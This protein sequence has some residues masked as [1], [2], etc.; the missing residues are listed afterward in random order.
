MNFDDNC[1][2]RLEKILSDFKEFN[3]ENREDF[4]LMIEAN[5]EFEENHKFVRRCIP[6]VLRYNLK[7]HI[8]PG[9]NYQNYSARSRTPFELEDP[10][11]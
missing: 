9:K 3:G 10:L 1:Q 8:F 5:K 6:L 7:Y 11:S 2:K 4:K